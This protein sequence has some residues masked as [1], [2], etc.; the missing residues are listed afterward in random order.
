MR[1]EGGG[2]TGGE[3]EKGGKPE[4][5]RGWEAGEKCQ[6]LLVVIF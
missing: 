4:S 5:V 3:R 2:G 6:T 1:G